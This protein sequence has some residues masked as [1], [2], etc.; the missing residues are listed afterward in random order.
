MN[1]SL[2]KKADP[3]F[4]GAGSPAGK[5]GFTL[6]DAAAAALFLAIGAYLLWCARYGVQNADESTYY[7][8]SHRLFFGDAPIVHEWSMTALTFPF[9]Y[10]PLRL[11]YAVTGSMEGSILFMRY[12][13]TGVKMVFY[14]YVYLSLR[15]YGW[16]SLLA[17]VVYT[18][19][20]PVG[21]RTVNYYNMAPNAMLIVATILV[22]R[23]EPKPLAVVFAGFVF[24]C[25]VIAEPLAALI[26]F[27]YSACVLLAVLLKRKQK[28]PFG[29][30]RTL[31]SGKT[32]I[33]LTVGIA[34]CAVGYLAM[35]FAWSSPRAVF[36]A[37]PDLLSDSTFS[38]TG[39]SALKLFKWDK[40]ERL[41]RS[42][43]VAATVLTLAVTAAALP[44]RKK[45]S[46]FRRPFFLIGCAVYAFATVS[47]F[48]C[49][50]NNEHSLGLLFFKPLLIGVFGLFCYLLTEKRDP[51]LLA[52]MICGYLISAAID[53][54][55]QTVIGVGCVVSDVPAVLALGTL[56][57]E[58]R[59]AV[60]EREPN[61]GC[62]RAT[63]L[64]CACVALAA[65]IGGEAY[66]FAMM[67]PLQVVEYINHMQPG[68][69]MTAT[70]ER[71]PLKGIV[72]LPEIKILVDG[73]MLD[74]D[75]I[76]LQNDGPFY[77]AN[78]CPWF[79]LYADLP[80]A[81]YSASYVEE[82]SQTRLLRY[83][84]KFPEKR[85]VCIYIPFYSCRTYFTDLMAEKENADA[86]LAFFGSVCEFERSVG[87]TGYIL[88]I[89]SWK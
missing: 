65:T 27:A 87:K 31:F 61:A 13:F 73:A 52:F 51:R 49:S 21:L 50:A 40:I 17:A 46:R 15:E 74:L 57:K 80:Y 12:L 79:Y 1:R 14:A 24:A 9:Q 58:L 6:C 20:T 45:L 83:W 39:M 18:G 66:N 3:A 63:V 62:A 10:L 41:L 8:F 60:G 23:R 47:F 59:E 43:G 25:A 56:L 33:R 16:W 88:K 38:S 64:L 4:A 55:S 5:R 70:V 75:A 76:G 69:A 53:I 67:R 35:L 36:D 30:F 77:V 84:E 7:T 44:I 2:F 72:T 82:D 32:W 29:T 19:F 78:F 34:V 68:K 22:M 85:P 37:I 28:T 26:Y 42:S 54:P 81:T 89:T 71:G 48:V 11:F 86:K